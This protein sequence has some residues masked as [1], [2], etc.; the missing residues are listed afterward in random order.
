MK[1]SPQA[2]RDI[3]MPILENQTTLLLGQSGM[4]KSSLLNLIVPDANAATREI[5]EALQSGRHTTTDARLYQVPQEQGRIIDTPGFQEFGLAHLTV[6]QIE[7]AFREFQTLLGHCR[8]YNCTH[9]IEPGCAV[10]DA[11]DRGTVDARRYALF[12]DLTRESNVG[13]RSGEPRN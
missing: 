10:R 5:S 1:G 2:A 12:S 6:G 11:V 3:L 8:F 7:R 13:A 4:G 9:L